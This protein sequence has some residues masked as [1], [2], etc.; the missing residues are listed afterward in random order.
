[1]AAR[2]WVGGSNTWDAIAGTKWA[3]TNGAAGGQAIPT[4][5]D[6]VF[7][8]A[9]SGGANTITLGSG[10]SPNVSTLTM[11]GFTGTFDF[12]S[13]NVT[14]SGTGTIYTGANT[15]IATGNPLIVCSNPSSTARTIS[16]GTAASITEANAVSIGVTSGF[17]A[18]TITTNHAVKNLNFTGFTGSLVS[19]NRTIYGSL[20]FGSGM[21]ATDGTGVYTF[22]S[23]LVQ[24]NITTNGVTLGGPITVN[25]TQTIQLQDALTLNSTRTF[26]LTA[27]TLDLNNKT[28][29]T[30]FFSSSNSNQR[31]IAFGSSGQIYVIGSGS[32]AWNTTTSTNLTVTGITGGTIHMT[33]SSAKT[34]AGGGLSYP[35]LN[36]GGT[37][38]LT[39]SGNNTFNDMTNS[40][41]PTTITF[42]A[43]TNNSFTQFNVGGSSGNLVTINSSSPGTKYTLT[44]LL[45]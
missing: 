9:L 32:T 24:Q 14:V 4:P 8:T 21:T 2:Y 13:Q 30:G 12:N 33:S 36:Q 1:M 37:G 20:T 43:G 45:G 40:V 17:G 25:G 3:L 39:V 41:Q 7:F 26:T 44:N 22:A 6:T 31:Q 27:G 38:A 34:F 19:G 5:A 16:P 15:F 42:T 23:T 18:V 11:T 28:L 35:R 29:T 10:Y